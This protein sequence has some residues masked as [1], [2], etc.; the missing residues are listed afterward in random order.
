VYSKSEEL[1]EFSY[2]EVVT[3][4]LVSH[5][6]IWFKKDLSFVAPDSIHVR[7]VET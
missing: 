7:L 2:F 5:E 6:N 3:C 1:N 4:Y